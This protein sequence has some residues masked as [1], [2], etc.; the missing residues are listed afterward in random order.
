[1]ERKVRRK[2][3]SIGRTDPLKGYLLLRRKR[4][5]TRSLRRLEETDQMVYTWQLLMVCYSASSLPVHVSVQ[6]SSKTISIFLA[7]SVY[8]LSFFCLSYTLFVK[9]FVLSLF[10]Y[11]LTCLLSLPVLFFNLNLSSLYALLCVLNKYIF[12][13]SINSQSIQSFSQIL[14]LS[15]FFGEECKFSFLK[16]FFFG[17][18]LSP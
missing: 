3:D 15:Y 2:R 6:H 12:Y 17:K 10:I 5:H 4:I 7:S 18:F 11:L 16:S 1:M 14:E 9:Y 13:T 8:F